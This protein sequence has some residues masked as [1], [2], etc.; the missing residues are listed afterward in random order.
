MF[1]GKSRLLSWNQVFAEMRENL[2]KSS[3]KT[4]TKTDTIYYGNQIRY[5][6]ILIRVGS[7]RIFM[8]LTKISQG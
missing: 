4:L 7:A 1:A 5:S 3:R 6:G 2:R 8:T